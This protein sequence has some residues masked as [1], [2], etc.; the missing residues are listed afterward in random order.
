MECREDPEGH[1]HLRCVLAQ[2]DSQARAGS[3]Q[4][5][6]P[7]P[8]DRPR[9]WQEVHVHC[10]HSWEAPVKVDVGQVCVVRII[11]RVLP[12]SLSFH[13]GLSESGASTASVCL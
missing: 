4:G 12:A 5:T 10:L 11:L 2:P 6:G 8:L 1:C 13:V 9:E 3:R 7:W